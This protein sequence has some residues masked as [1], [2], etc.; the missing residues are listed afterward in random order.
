MTVAVSEEDLAD[1]HGTQASADTILD[2]LEEAW[3]SVDT[4][5]GPPEECP[6]DSVVLSGRSEK[7]QVK[8]VWHSRDLDSLLV[9]SAAV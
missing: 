6:L 3:V 1:S 4:Y 8:D 7:T 9:E 2:F 5:L